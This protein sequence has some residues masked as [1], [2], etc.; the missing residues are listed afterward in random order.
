M[1]KEKELQDLQKKEDAATDEDVKHALHYM[2]EVTVEVLKLKFKKDKVQGLAKLVL[3][4]LRRKAVEMQWVSP[5]QAQHINSIWCPL[6]F[7]CE[8]MTDDDEEELFMTFSTT[9]RAYHCSCTQ[10]PKSQK[11]QSEQTS[12]PVPKRGR[13]THF[14]TPSQQ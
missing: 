9:P 13:I 14:F 10:K 4:E 2:L 7:P 8:E 1:E 3:L 6:P 12:T 5:S 11:R